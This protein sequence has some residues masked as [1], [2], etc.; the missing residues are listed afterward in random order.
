MLI[1]LLII[2]LITV[3]LIDQSG[4]IES[5]KLFIS[6]ALTKGKIPSTN[7][8]LKPL[9]CSFCMNHWIGLLFLLLTHQLTLV[10]YCVVL[11]L[12][13]ATPIT[14]SILLLIKDLVLYLIN[15]NYKWLK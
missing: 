2:Q 10:S 15:L 3:I 14:N 5:F 9:D 4:A 11:L 13:F 8:S 7:F 1:D 12:S 6:N